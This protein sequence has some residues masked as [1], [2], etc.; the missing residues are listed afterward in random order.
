MRRFKYKAVVK[1]GAGE[2]WS[3]PILAGNSRGDSCRTHRAAVFTYRGGI[4]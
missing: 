3:Q 4:I 2:G 1:D